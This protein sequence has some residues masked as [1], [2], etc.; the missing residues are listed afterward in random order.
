MPNQ[1]STSL[2]LGLVTLGLPSSSVLLGLLS[3][4]VLLM[5]GLP[6][7]SAL[8]LLRCRGGGGRGLGMEGEGVWP[9][10]RFFLLRFR[11]RVSGTALSLFLRLEPSP[12]PSSS[13]SSDSSASGAAEPSRR[14]EGRMDE[15][16]LARGLWPSLSPFVGV[17][18]ITALFVGVC[19]ITALFVGVCATYVFGVCTT[20][21]STGRW[22]LTMLFSSNGRRRGLSNN[23][24]PAS[25]DSSWL[26]RRPYTRQ[27]RGA[28]PLPASSHRDPPTEPAGTTRSTAS[29][30]GSI[31]RLVTPLRRLR[32]EVKL[33]GRASEVLTEREEDGQ[34]PRLPPLRAP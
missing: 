27:G 3:S 6:S 33:G 21:S 31:A 18:T 14:G 23:T 29:S 5:L 11:L 15:E 20:T 8:L 12:I 10:L 1:L 17:C 9:P 26:C 16:V 13:S 4:S 32:G 25:T 30:S 24:L 34:L 2:F 22:I 7:S 28:L 19:K